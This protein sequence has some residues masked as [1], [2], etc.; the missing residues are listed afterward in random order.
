MKEWRYVIV[1]YRGQ[2]MNESRGVVML[3]QEVQENGAEEV[4]EQVRRGGTKAAA[5]GCVQP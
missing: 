1:I 2:Q 4:V 3:Q 5:A